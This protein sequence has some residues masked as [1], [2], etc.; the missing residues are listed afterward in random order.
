MTNNFHT[1]QEMLV[2]CAVAQTLVHSTQQT[3]Y[4]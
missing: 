4:Y 1:A 2:S 3:L